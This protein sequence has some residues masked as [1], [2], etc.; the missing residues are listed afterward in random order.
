MEENMLYETL[1]FWNTVLK[2]HTASQDWNID[3][4]I[5]L[6]KKQLLLR[7][8]H[9]GDPSSPPIL[10]VPPNAGHHSNI[11]ER[12]LQTCIDATPERSIYSI[13]WPGADSSNKGYGIEDMVCELQ[14]CVEAVGNR[15][16]LF[17]L[18]QGAWVSAIYASLFPRTVLSYTNGAGPIDFRAGNGKIKDY[19]SVMPDSFFKG[20]VQYNGGI[21]TG[22]NQ[23][24]GFKNLNPFERWVSDYMNL[25]LDILSG[26]EK[27]IERWKR[28]KQWYEHTVDL[29]GKWYLEAVQELFKKNK[30]I[31]GELEVLSKKVDLAN[32][33]CPVFLLAGERD[34]ITPP[35]QVFNM[36][37][38]VSGPTWK[39]L[40]E[41]AGHIGVFVKSASLEYWKSIIRQ[42]DILENGLQA[43][44]RISDLSPED[45]RLSPD[46]L[47][48][49]C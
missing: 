47:Y 41:D 13:D 45:Y 30:L 49:V 23:V 11:A 42:L 8:F 3:N 2:T 44:T 12:L 21:Q 48:D 14:S 24:L 7:R 40:I 25:W 35:K 16:H 15:V 19:C 39:A 1:R 29:D 43:N 32:I 33:S 34:D 17:T 37:D 28:F 36:A 26:E 38:Y 22:L 27:K 9:R 4:E 18:C 5:I 20:L 31:K 10:V 6:E 46:L